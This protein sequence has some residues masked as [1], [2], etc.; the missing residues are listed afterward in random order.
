MRSV[1][2]VKL[3]DEHDSVVK[4]AEAKTSRF[5]WMIET[6]GQKRSETES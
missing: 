5:F 2:Y 3:V 1:A 4:K 6:E